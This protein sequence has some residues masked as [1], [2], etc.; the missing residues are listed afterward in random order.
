MGKEIHKKQ[1]AKYAKYTNVRVHL[2]QEQNDLINATMW[3]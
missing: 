2:Q 3:L 1:G